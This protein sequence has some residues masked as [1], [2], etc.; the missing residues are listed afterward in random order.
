[1][2]EP[3]LFSLFTSRLNDRKLNY[4]VTGSVATI[5]YGEPRL[6]HDIDIVLELGVG[7]IASFVL[8]FPASEFSVAPIEKI[9]NEILRPE[10]GHF[11]LIHLETG[12]K[13][14]IYLKGDDELHQWALDNKRS[15]EFQGVMLPLAPPEYVII[16]KLEYFRDGQSDKHLTDIKKILDNSPEIIDLA[17]I[18]A[19]VRRHGLVELWEKSKR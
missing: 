16:R 18:D 8:A 14:D 13:A 12:F 17:Y 7:E 2:Q 15:F 5:A 3:N 10:R 11:Y 6:T 9:K 1:M 4:A 19:Y